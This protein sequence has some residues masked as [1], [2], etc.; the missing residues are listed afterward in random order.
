MRAKMTLLALVMVFPEPMAGALSKIQE[1][2][3]TSGFGPDGKPNNEEA[4]K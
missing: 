3:M 2:L 1:F 4:H